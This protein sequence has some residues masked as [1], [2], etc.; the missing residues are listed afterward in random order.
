MSN[1]LLIVLNALR[2]AQ[3]IVTAGAEQ[4]VMLTHLTDTL[5]ND[6]VCRALASLSAAAGDNGQ[7]PL[8]PTTIAAS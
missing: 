6:D 1:D 7:E 5:M 2:A 3:A 4:Q 8:G